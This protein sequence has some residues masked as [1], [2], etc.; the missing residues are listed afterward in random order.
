MYQRRRVLQIWEQAGLKKSR[1]KHVRN[2]IAL[3]EKAPGHSWQSYADKL[4]KSYPRALKAILAPLV[5]NDDPLIVANAL[6]IANLK[7]KN[8]REV[9]A[10]FAQNAD[11]EKH[12][13]AL[14]LIAQI[15]TEAIK[16]E[17]AKRKDLSPKVRQLLADRH[18]DDKIGV[19]KAKA[20]PKVR[21][22]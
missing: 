10:D 5:E 15:G 13:Y 1:D 12:A 14:E 3:V 6:R 17:M 11:A 9:V 8:E 4:R 18:L 22:S 7:K 21:T 20:V 19:S 16:K 2:F